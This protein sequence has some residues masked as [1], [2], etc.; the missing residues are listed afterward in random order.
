MYC[1]YLQVGKVP[2][3]DETAY[4]PWFRGGITGG[5]EGRKEGRRYYD[6]MRKGGFDRSFNARSLAWL[7]LARS[8]VRR[9]EMEEPTYT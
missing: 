2:Y 8:L 3:V 9:W 5:R 1:T 6:A 4:V 7:G